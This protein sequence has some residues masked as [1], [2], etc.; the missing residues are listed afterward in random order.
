MVFIVLT[1]S[2]RP[3]LKTTGGQSLTLS[4]NNSRAQ[5]CLIHLMSSPLAAPEF[6]KLSMKYVWGERMH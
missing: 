1:P 2:P 5:R 3:A 4:L 6:V